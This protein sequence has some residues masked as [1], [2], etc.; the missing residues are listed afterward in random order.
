[1]LSLQSPDTV[2]A[3]PDL[4]QRALAA[5]RLAVEYAQITRETVRE[6]RETMSYG[7]VAKLLGISRTRVQQ[8]E[9]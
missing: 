5:Q 1:M 3:I 2:R 4:T 7:E 8:L 6:M 9:K